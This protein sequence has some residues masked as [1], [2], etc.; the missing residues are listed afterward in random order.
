VGSLLAD[1]AYTV[2]ADTSVAVAERCSCPDLLDNRSA[3]KL[4]DSVA[5]AF[6]DRLA[7][8]AVTR[9]RRRSEGSAVTRCRLLEHR[10]LDCRDRSEHDDHDDDGRSDDGGHRSGDARG[11]RGDDDREDATKA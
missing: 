8:P 9:C 11:G 1:L 4:L 2:A 3:R 6:P 7:D 5:E 10:A